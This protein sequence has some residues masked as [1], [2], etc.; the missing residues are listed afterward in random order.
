MAK[1]RNLIFVNSHPIQYF[2]PLYKYLNKNGLKCSAWY[3]SDKSIKGKI[4]NEFGVKV[5]WDIP[6][7]EGYDY[8]FYRNFGR[9]EEEGSSFFSLVN[10]GMI[11]QLF[12]IHP[13]VIVVHGWNF[14][15]HFFILMLGRLAGHTICLRNDMPYSHELL[16]SGFKQK[17]KKL[18]LKYIVFPRIDY[19]CAVGKENRLFYKSYDIRENKI[20]DVPYVVD[21]ERFQNIEINTFAVRAKYKIPLKDKVILF[22]GKYIDKKRPLDLLNAFKA[23]NRNDCWLIFI[24]DGNLKPQ[25]E[26]YIEENGLRKVLLTGFINQSEIPNWYAIGDLFVMC[27]GQGENWG[28]SVNEAMNFNLNVVLSDLTG[29]AADLVV[30]GSN[31]FV[32]KTGDVTGLKN[33]ILSILYENGL[34]ENSI[35][36]KELID[37]YSFESVYQGLRPLLDNV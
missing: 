36:S 28:L 13:S 20:I 9:N 35:N 37:K 2:A 30:E 11:L 32:Y 8:T 16:K 5:K 33:C 21:N 26:A 15:S 4:D 27:S 22:S 10:P 25:M 1:N 3:A 24:G 34:S 17:I 14:F 18:G 6:L 23:L 19:F 29:C 7:L 31:G 12:K